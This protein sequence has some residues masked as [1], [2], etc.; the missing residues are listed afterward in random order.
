MREGDVYRW[1]YKNDEAYRQANP[2]TAYWCM[3][4]QCIAI[5]GQLVDTYWL[6][7]L[8][9]VPKKNSTCSILQEDK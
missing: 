6:S 3:D 1:Y 7:W 2:S 4:N 9:D 5:D 8:E